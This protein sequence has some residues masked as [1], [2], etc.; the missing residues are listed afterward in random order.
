VTIDSGVG[1]GTSF[2]LFF[3]AQE[4]ETVPAVDAWRQLDRWADEG[5]AIIAPRATPAA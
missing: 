3:P 2:D 1:Q 5:G 4:E